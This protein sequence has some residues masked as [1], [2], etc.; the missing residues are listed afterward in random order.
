MDGHTYVSA[1]MLKTQSIAEQNKCIVQDMVKETID[2]CK[3]GLFASTFP[4]P[5]NSY[6]HRA[7]QASRRCYGQIEN[8]C[9]WGVTLEDALDGWRAERRWQIVVQRWNYLS[10]RICAEES[11]FLGLDASASNTKYILSAQLKLDVANGQL[12]P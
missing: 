5:A 2:G 9:A 7:P 8:H 4:F 12:E 10:P 3:S 11:C 6:L 1:P